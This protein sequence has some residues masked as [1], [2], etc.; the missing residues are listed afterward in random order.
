VVA[1][2]IRKDGRTKL[3]VDC[4]QFCERESEPQHMVSTVT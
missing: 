4:S 3:V 2:Y 1:G